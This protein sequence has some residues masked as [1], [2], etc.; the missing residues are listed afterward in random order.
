MAKERKEAKEEKLE[1]SR[2]LH[3]RLKKDTIFMVQTASVAVEATTHSLGALAKFLREVGPNKGKI[4]KAEEASSR[5]K[6]TAST[7]LLDEKRQQYL[8]RT[9]PSC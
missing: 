5:W 4:L 6:K 9:N 8:Q 2:D 3:W 1:T 7:T